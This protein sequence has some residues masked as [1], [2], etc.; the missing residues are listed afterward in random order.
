MRISD[1]SSDVCSSDLDLDSSMNA[2]VDLNAY[3]NGKW[4]AA[5][6]VPGDRTSWGAFEMLNERSIAVQHQLAEQAAADADAT[7]VKKIVGD[8]WA[9]GMDEAK[10]NAQ[11]ITPIQDRL[12]A[13]AKLDGSEAIAEYLRTSAARGENFL[14]GFGRSEEHT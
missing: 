2:C 11:G 6:P 3:A 9:T 13:I 8:F 7:G 5:N 10:I 4:L 14:F 12:D 1:W